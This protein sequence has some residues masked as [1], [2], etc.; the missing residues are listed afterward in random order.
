M[1][2]GKYIRSLTSD[3]NKTYYVLPDEIQKA[4]TIP[5]PCIQDVEDR[6]G[7]VDVL[8]GLMKHDNIDVCD[9][10]Q[11]ENAVLRYLDGISRVR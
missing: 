8:L 2:L 9:R 11:F 5:N 6:I 7:F 10:Q 1:E 3:E 4:V